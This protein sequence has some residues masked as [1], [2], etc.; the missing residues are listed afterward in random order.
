MVDEMVVGGKS[1]ERRK[2]K[3]VGEITE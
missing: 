2:E 3:G 1:G